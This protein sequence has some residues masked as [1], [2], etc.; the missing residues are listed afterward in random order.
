MPR[1]K[2]KY[3]NTEKGFGFIAQ[4]DG[5]ADVFIHSSAIDS[6]Y[7]DIRVGQTVKYQVTEERSSWKRC[8]DTIDST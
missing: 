7:D 2:I 6:P 3:Y 1:G 4:D 5:E 8:R